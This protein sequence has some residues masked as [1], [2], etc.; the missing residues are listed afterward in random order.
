MIASSMPVVLPVGLWCD[1]VRARE[2]VVR[3]LTG[4]DQ[5]F[6][7]EAG[8][9]MLAAHRTTALLSR[10]VQ[11]I[12]PRQPVT[13]ELAAQL[14]VGDREALMWHLRQIMFGERLEPIVRCPAAECGKPMDVP[15]IVSD[16]LVGASSEPVPEYLERDLPGVGP[17]RFRLPCGEDQEAVAGL[18]TRDARAAARML[19]CRCTGLATDDLP[20]GA[21]EAVSDWMVEL[22]PQAEIRL[23][24]ICPECGQAFTSLLDAGVYLFEETAMRS[25]ELYREVHLLA[26]HYHWSEKEILGMTP[27]KRKR[28]IELVLESLA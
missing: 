15:L 12:G 21:L 14:V 24:L 20:A 13:P 5:E 10:C 26:S 18:A 3:P 22:D 25:R 28:Y 19:L 6:L 2:S 9:S 23:D 27:P 4:A 7:I 17:L 11:S 1:G 8:D 16:L